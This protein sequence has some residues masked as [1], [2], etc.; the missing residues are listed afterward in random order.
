MKNFRVLNKTKIKLILIISILI[1]QGIFLLIESKKFIS[2][3]T[4]TGR[5][6]N[7]QAWEAIPITDANG[8]PLYN[9]AT[10]LSR[11]IMFYDANQ[12]GKNITGNNRFNWRGDCHVNDGIEWTLSNGQTIWIDATG[13]YHDAGDHIK[14]G[15]TNAYAASTLGWGLYEFRDQYEETGQLN[16]ILRAIKW[17]TDYFIKCHPE[18]NSFLYSVGSSEDHNFWGPPEL[19]LDSR[20]PRDIVVCTPSNP[21]SDVC[22][23]TAGAL[24]LMYI[25]YIDIDPDYANLCLQ[26]GKEIYDL[27]R[28]NLGLSDGLAFYPP[29]IYWDD[30]AWGSIWLY[31][32]TGDEAYY[33]DFKIILGPSCAGI[34][35]D[36]D[37]NNGLN[38]ENTW[39]HCWDAVWAG[40]FAAASGITGHA[41]FMEQVETNL[42]YWMYDLAET[43]AGLKYLNEWGVLRYATASALCGLVYYK[44]SGEIIY[45]DFAASQI[46]YALGSNPLDRCY[47]VGC[48]TNPPQHPHHDAAHGSETGFLDDPPEHKHVLYGALVGGPGMDDQHNDATDDYVQNEVSIDYNAAMVGALAGMRENFGPDLIPDPD[49]EPEPPIQAYWVESRI[50]K[51]LNERSQL[52]FYIQNHAIHPPHYEYDLLFRYYVDLSEVFDQ[53][54][55]LENINIETVVNENQDAQVAQEFTPWDELNYIYYVEI[56]YQGVELYNK[57]EVQIALIY[58][59]PNFEGIWDPTNDFSHLPMTEIL[60]PNENIPLYRGG[61]L[62]WGS[63]PYKDL[64]P[65]EKPTGITTSVKG[66]AQI[67][68]DWNDNSET[69]LSHYNIYHSIN[70]Q[71]EI[72]SESLAGSSGTSDFSDTELL[73]ETI[74]Y[75]KITAVDTNENEGLPSDIVSATTLTPDPY[76]PASPTGLTVIDTG[77]SQIEL[78][79]NDNSEDD[80]SKYKVYRSTISGFTCDQTTYIGDTIVSNYLDIDLSSDTTYYYKVIAIDT[81][82]NPSDPSDQISATTD[83]IIAQLRAKYICGNQDST[84]SEVRA[85]IQIQNDGPLDVALTDVTVRYWFTSEPALSDLTYSCDYAAVGSSGITSTFGSTGDSDYLEIGFTSSATVPTWLGGDGSSNS[86]LIGA[87]TGDIQN[88]I[89]RNSNIN[90]DQTND[91]SFDPSFSAYSDANQITVYYQGILVWGKEPPTGPISEP[92]SIN[93]PAN[94]NYQEGDTGNSITWTATDDNPTIYIVTRGNTQVASGSWSSGSPI[95]MI[96]DGLSLGTYTYT[97]TVTD[98]DGQMDSDS[99]TVTVSQSTEFQ[100]GDVNHDSNVDIVDALMIAQYYVGL[101]PQP[102]YPEEADVDNS[103]SIDIVDALMVAQAYVGLIELPP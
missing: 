7:S 99:V 27:G 100:N 92:P 46:N 47:I 71:F 58:N 20:S 13:G 19:Q 38:W 96:V 28:N 82:N 42:D 72:N 17:A 1:F 11:T 18:P 84:T 90:F 14:F 25:N 44:Y 32:A 30:L 81:S 5:D 29:S 91:H 78:N 21:A 75:Y 4:M 51:D 10:M 79:W 74:Y 68:L 94:V 77:S 67:D 35:H 101:D 88:R 102:F 69:D 16:N 98:G 49:P 61:E 53:G 34:D 55:G 43:P 12:C 23:L 33:D 60:E 76:P 73:A 39:T 65:P 54:Y 40:V 15:I 64:I 57:R 31:K 80:L 52:T 86:L 70:S 93:S 87:N 95:T 41:A 97:C 24:A 59:T 63:E 6:L 3:T 103:G 83:K 37:I 36:D 2:L 89:G 50:E 26:H 8:G 62:L 85:Q 22:G 9:Y 66:S 48:G 45:R 56:S